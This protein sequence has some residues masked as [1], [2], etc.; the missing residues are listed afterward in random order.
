MLNKLKKFVVLALCIV[1]L[2]Q[3]TSA[4]AISFSDVNKTDRYA[5]AY[6]Y[7]MDLAN[8]GI[9]N[10][11]EDG[12]FKPGQTV[13]YLEII[14]LLVG[15]M[16]PTQQEKNEAVTKY[17]TTMTNAG[18]PDWARPAVA[19]ALN[20]GV[21]TETELNAAKTAGLIETGTNK[22]V[23]RM[24][25]SIYTARALELTP[26]SV[27]VLSYKDANTIDKN[28]V[29]LIAALI[30]TEVLHKDGRDGFF[31]GDKPILRS[32]ISKMIKTAYD[33]V[34]KNPL[35]KGVSTTKTETGT[36]VSYN[37]IG[38][39]NYFVY[40]N[41]SGSTISTLVT[42]STKITNRN[43]AT[44]AQSDLMKYENASLSMTYKEV[45]GTKEATEIKFTTD[46]ST[47]TTGQTYTITSISTWSSTINVEYTQNGIKRTGAYTYN[48]STT[49]RKGGVVV[50][51]NSLAKD[52]VIT[53][54]DLNGTVITNLEVGQTTTG[55]YRLTGVY[56]GS[57]P[58]VEIAPVSGG[59]STKYF[60]APTYTVL[61]NGSTITLSGL[62]ANTDIVDVVFSGNQIT[63]IEVRTSAQSGQ[64]RLTGVYAGTNP[65]VELAPINGGNSTRYFLTSNYSVI[66]NGVN[67]S[68]GSLVVNS[69]TVDVTF[70]GT[71]ISRIE[72][73]G[74]T[75]SGQYYVNEIYPG[76]GT[77]YGT[78]ING[79][80]K[81]YFTLENNALVTRNGG[82]TNLYNI[83]TGDRVN[84]TI[85][86]GNRV[87][88]LEAFSS[89]GTSGYTFRYVSGGRIYVR[90]NSNGNNEDFY[91]RTSTYYDVNNYSNNLNN[92]REGNLI[93]LEFYGN[94]ISAV[95]LMQTSG[96]GY[97][98]VRSVPYTLKASIPPASLG[99]YT[100]IEIEGSIY[101]LEEYELS[102]YNYYLNNN[103]QYDTGN[104]PR[105]GYVQVS[106]NANGTIARFDFG[107]N[108]TLPNVERV[109]A[110]YYTSR[111]G[112]DGVMTYE[113]TDGS[114]FY[115][116]TSN[117]WQ[118]SG[119]VLERWYYI[120]V[121][122]NNSNRI[123]KVEF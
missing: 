92:L 56:S 69:D 12:T 27:A 28:F 109:N 123:V 63:R 121:D 70:S 42:S 57:N 62:V 26:K 116:L 72:V 95:R 48:N 49:F 71:Q 120:Q 55:Q 20:R 3:S 21:A 98:T 111:L 32:E 39:N 64:Y 83:V 112:T 47:S 84:L 88:R 85:T 78:P 18:I 108:I 38:S 10:G 6:D 22:R 65:Y 75:Q 61:R 60:L 87:S 68:L 14:Q 103:R 94:E 115:S 89:V 80:T 100:K 53:K 11:Y 90:N 16:N 41:S 86:S 107:S 81:V 82:T 97:A 52:D 113:F 118:Y 33:W 29:N 104:I 117:D 51:V 5:W 31:D 43:N 23:D 24:T 46:G 37:P 1:I 67:S 74:S 106:Y 19:V 102:R 73:R 44:V 114:K 2:S 15:V 25:V 101:Q 77:F 58:Y 96:S 105:T 17:S 13:T 34:Q 93:N 50:N 79:G 9:I 122:T 119:L 8:K 91:L 35:K 59:S 4:M 76:S 45:G 54:L 30:D 40:K 36:M 66:R 7:I 110:R 99:H